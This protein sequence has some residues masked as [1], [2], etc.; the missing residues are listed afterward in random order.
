MVPVQGQP[1]LATDKGKAAS[2]LQQERLKMAN[3]RIL[4]I[5]FYEPMGFREI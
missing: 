5:A 1:F 2:Q 4:K 3:Q